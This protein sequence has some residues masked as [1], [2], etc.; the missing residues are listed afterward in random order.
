MISTRVNTKVKDSLFKKVTAMIKRMQDDLHKEVVSATPVD[1]GRAKR[2]WRRNSEG[3]R[4]DVPYIGRLDKGHSKQAPDGMSR[5][6]LN[7]VKSKTKRGTY[8]K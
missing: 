5:P 8:L 2:G 7:R 3:T 4:N 6:A 1:T